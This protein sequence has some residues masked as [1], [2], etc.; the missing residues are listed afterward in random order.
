MKLLKAGRARGWDNVPNEFLMNAPDEVLEAITTLFNKV[1]SSGTIPS[2]W[3]KGRI[4][5]IFKR[6]I[7]ELLNNYRPVTVIIALSGLYSRVLNSRLTQVVET[8]GLLGEEQNG[9][10]SGRRTADNNFLV[11]SA[12]WKGKSVK[13]NV[14]FCFI[15]ISKAYDSVCRTLL[16]SRLSSLGIG[17]TFLQSLKALYTGDS[18]ESEVNG[19]LTRPVFLSRGL[20]QGCS[21]SPILFAIYISGIGADLAASSLGFPLG[22]FI[23]SGLLF[24]DDIVLVSG[25]S[26]GLVQLVKLVKFHCDSLKLEISVEKSRWSLQKMTCLGTFWRRRTRSCYL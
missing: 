16:W 21:L 18:V 11:N 20:R 4:T 2:G 26:G 8:H 22:S 24:A 12:I 19:R 7:R 15:D 1:Q 25:D 14:H 5:L 6:G 23:L 9:F 3:N 13:Q 17:G 10:R